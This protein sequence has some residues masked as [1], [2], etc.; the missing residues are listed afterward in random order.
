VPIDNWH[1]YQAVLATHPVITKACTSGLVYALG[2]W[3][4]QVYEGRP[5]LGFD[6]ARVLRS[7]IV[8]LFMH[9][10]L[11]HY[12]YQF[13]E[14]RLPH[15]GNLANT[16]LQ[17]LIDQTFWAV[18]WNAMYYAALGAMQLESPQQIWKT[19]SSTWWELLKTGWKLWPLAH[20]GTYGFV[21]V[22]QRVLYVDMVELVWVTVLSAFANAK[23]EGS[24]EPA[25]ACALPQG[26]PSSEILRS[27]ETD[28]QICF[29]TAEGA[30]GCV[31]PE[32]V[33]ALQDELQEDVLRLTVTSLP[34]EKGELSV[35][36]SMVEGSE[37]QGKAGGVDV[38]YAQGTAPERELETSTTQ[39]KEA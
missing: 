32:A 7:A 20:I 23:K 34:D 4:A 15:D 27:I 24:Q 28:T 25:T 22:E 12:Y 33:Q 30:E 13:W 3:T 5:L 26:S 14:T 21:P 10:P 9:G 17:I 37:A 18:T 8:G 38:I 39:D 1:A 2:D 19:V 36:V 6:R 35:S 11:S 16:A 29:E 31:T